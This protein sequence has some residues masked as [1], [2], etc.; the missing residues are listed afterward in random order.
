LKRGPVSHP[1]SSHAG[2]ECPL[3]RVHGSRDGTGVRVSAESLTEQRLQNILDARPDVAGIREQ[4]RFTY[5]YRNEHDHYRD[6]LVTTTAGER[7]AGT[8]K[9]EARLG[10]GR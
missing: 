1:H 9:P 5:G 6:I 4:V 3:H 8:V 2:H 10:S 7:I